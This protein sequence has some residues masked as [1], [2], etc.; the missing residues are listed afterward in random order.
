MRRFHIALTLAA[1]L[2][3]AL[4]GSA[5]ELAGVD[6][7]DTATVASQSLQLNGMGLRKKFFIK[8]YVAGLYLPSKQTDGAAVLAADQ[9]RR[10]VMHFVYGVDKGKICGAWDEALEANYPA[11]SDVVKKQMTELCGYMEDMAKGDSMSFNYDP[12]SGTTVEVKGETKGTIAGKPFADALWSAWIGEHP[13]T[14]A[15]KEGLLGG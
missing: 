14:D 5:G 13:A 10:T 1:A 11:A 3:V 2:L 6:M 9:S 7:P 4:P 8:V 12:E 15:L